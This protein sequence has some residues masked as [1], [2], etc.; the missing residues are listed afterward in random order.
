MTHF[1]T[2]QIAEGLRHAKAT[3]PLATRW[4]DVAAYHLAASFQQADPSFERATCLTAV[5]FR[6]D[7]PGDDPQATDEELRVAWETTQETWDILQ[8]VSRL[9]VR[10]DQMILPYHRRLEEL[11]ALLKRMNKR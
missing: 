4:F 1:S 10:A 3:Y 5:N 6:T 2:V 9:G 11:S 7:V 8:H